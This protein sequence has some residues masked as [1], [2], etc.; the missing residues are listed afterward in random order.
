MKRQLSVYLRINF[1]DESFTSSRDKH[2]ILCI[3][4]ISKQ[5]ENECDSLIY[6]FDC[7]LLFGK[8]YSFIYR[9]N[10]L[11]FIFCCVFMYFFS[12]HAALEVAYSITFL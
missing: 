8:S 11:T 7:L 6:G 1:V 3:R 5:R 12:C 10:L 9:V 2:H 4:Y